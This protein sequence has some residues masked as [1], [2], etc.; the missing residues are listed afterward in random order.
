M[1]YKAANRFSPHHYGFFLLASS[2]VL[3]S[4]CSHPVSRKEV[5]ADTS[6]AAN[7]S[8]ANVKQKIK[9]KTPEKNATVEVDQKTK[10]PILFSDARTVAEIDLTSSDP[11][12]DYSLNGQNGTVR[13][14]TN[15][16][17]KRH[18][19]A[20]DN[21][22]IAE[23]K[24]DADSF[25]LKGADGRLL[26]KIKF[27]DSKIKIANTEEMNNAFVLKPGETDRIKVL[28][29]ETEIGK[30]KFYRERGKVKVE[31]PADVAQYE[32]NTNLFSGAY[33]VL[34]MNDIPAAERLIIM[35]EL[36]A[37]GR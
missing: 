7:V 11:K 19:E 10:Q 34:L 23:I 16:K 2:F 17:G 21:R 14:K 24:A 27:V 20:E 13:G 28:R 22:T 8:T 31:N 15:D 36:L 30:V 3:L 6:S 1:R 25:K 29:E 35:T 9:I 5:P 33:G 18:Y 12:I 26:W 4:A 32:S 37:R